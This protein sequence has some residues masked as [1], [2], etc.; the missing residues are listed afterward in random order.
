MH[1]EFIEE[2]FC[3]S[4]FFVDYLVGNYGAERDAEG[5]KAVEE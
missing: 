1:F 5:R 2:L 3:Y 4:Y